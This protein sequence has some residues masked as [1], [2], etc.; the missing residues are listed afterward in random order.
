MNKETRFR[1]LLLLVGFV[2][3]TAAPLWA[4]P[5]TPATDEE[6]K[7]M[8]AAAGESKDYDNAS[9]VYVLDEA[10]VFVL[11][12]GLATTESCQVIKILNDAGV[13]DNSAHKFEFDPATNRITLKS[14]RI[15]RKGGEIE[16]VPLGETLVQSAP[17]HMIYWGNIQQVLSLPR[18][19]IGDTLEIRRSKI[20]YN[21]AYLANN[22]EGGGAG[23]VGSDHLQPPMPGHWHESTEFQTWY[24]IIKKRYSVHMPM[25]KPLQYKVCND[26]L[27]SSLWIDGDK[28]VYSFFAENMPALK[29]EPRMLDN[30]DIVPKLVMA[31]VPDWETKS[32]WFWQAN[33]DQFESNDEINAMVAEIT[34]PYETENEKVEALLHWVAD[35]I[36]YYGTSRGPCEGF[37]LHTGIETFKD[38]GGVCKDIAGM[39]VTMLRAMGLESYPS[40][41]MAGSRVEAIPADQFNHTVTVLKHKDGTFRVLD[42]TWSP[43]SRETWSSWEAEQGLV[44]GTPEGETLTLSPYFPPE[45]NTLSYTGESRLDDAGNLSVDFAVDAS[46][47]PCTSYR[48][49]FGR[50]A[51][52]DYDS[53]FEES[54]EIAPNAVIEK[55]ERTHIHDY[56]RDSQIKMELSADDYAAVGGGAAMFKLPLMARPFKS[57]LI[58]DFDYDVSAPERK[59]GLR[60]RASRRLLIEETVKLPAGWKVVRTP[61]A[62]SVDGKMTTFKF[63]MTP[64]DG[65][66]TYKLE[67]IVR[68]NIVP[69][70]EYKDFKA[71]IESLRN[72]KDEWI[73]CETGDAVALA[74]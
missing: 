27:R 32:R 51:T 61:E 10:D 53:V 71:A 46:N 67:M 57:W 59:Y 30:P 15:H 19:E 42:P 41:T 22:Y 38:R 58:G 1:C 18:L 37:T 62:K 54:L 35:N 73:V 20:G 28:M 23:P 65:E 34:A 29:G 52:R 16:D 12:S 6:I 31:T 11:E 26:G 14:I 43:D 74:N 72:L 45:N 39:L 47:S 36:R 40:L 3:A 69:P 21:I 50:R 33:K 7:T 49:T 25:D 5:P 68:S 48:R 70:E 2:C 55:L 4:G 17:Q 56:S 8:I 60:L 9:V 13:R 24:P 64:G 63:E 66:I 44:Y